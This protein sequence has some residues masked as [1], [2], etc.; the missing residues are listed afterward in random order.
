MLYRKLNSLVRDITAKAAAAKE[1]PSPADRIEQLLAARDE[2]RERMRNLER[3]QGDIGFAGFLGFFPGMGMMIAGATGFLAAPSLAAVTGVLLAAPLFVAGAALAAASFGA[4]ALAGR[5][6]TA[7]AQT[8]TPLKKASTAKLS[9]SSRR[10]RR[11]PTSRGAT[12]DRW[13]A[14]IMRRRKATRRMKSLRRGCRQKRQKP[15][16]PRRHE[17]NIRPLRGAEAAPRRHARANPHGV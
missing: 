4:M 16:P 13:S 12:W 3:R 11:K 5:P 6:S 9:K 8:A 2:S 14:F 17:G 10:I 15:P 7:C 1:A